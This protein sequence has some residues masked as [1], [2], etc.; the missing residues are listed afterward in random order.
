MADI[1]TTDNLFVSSPSSPG[2]YRKMPLG[3]QSTMSSPTILLPG[4]ILAPSSLSSQSKISAS[5]PLKLG[6]GLRLLSQRDQSSQSPPAISATHAG[7]LSTDAKRN[8]VTV[9]PFLKRRYL[10]A[11]N[12][13]VI[14]Q[15]H[16]SGPDYFYCTL[17]PNTPHV[18]LAQLSFEGATKKTRPM[19]KGSELVYARVLS[20]GSGA[21]EE[22][23][24]TCVNPATGKAEPE[25]LGPLI[26]GTVF[27]ISTGLATRL[28]TR[29]SS[30]AEGAGGVVVLQ[31]LGKKMEA[32]GGFE[33]AIGRN[34]K[35]WVDCSGSGASS[36]KATA[37]IGR[38]LKDTDEQC[39]GIPEQ[40][41]LVSKVLRELGLSS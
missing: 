16:H 12:D 20:V 8:T 19:L 4:D 25:G 11:P 32:L 37:A 26:G 33:V 9:T 17:T 13:L 35:I 40:K 22:V 14:A 2:R 1:N 3:H 27:D 21:S 6:Q 39:L 24:L 36:I 18:L 31:E 23:E 15:I 41:K 30:S 10:P 34:G 29:G 28:M 5:T 7:L 38:C